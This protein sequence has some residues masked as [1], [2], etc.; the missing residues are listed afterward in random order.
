[1]AVLKL[2]LLHS[3]QDTGIESSSSAVRN[4]L[5]KGGATQLPSQAPQ[6][7]FYDQIFAAASM[8]DR[9]L[10][11]MKR[12]SESPAEEQTAPGSE[13]GGEGVDGELAEVMQATL[14]WAEKHVVRLGLCPH[15]KKVLE[16][17]GMKTLVR[18]DITEEEDAW[19]LFLA[20]GRARD[21]PCQLPR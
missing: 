3:W 13:L 14:R 11:S 21:A 2:T 15:A 19:R 9:E 6:P 17:G 1:M 7:Q 16:G 12:E 20:E 4:S 8:V 5:G 18:S 10:A